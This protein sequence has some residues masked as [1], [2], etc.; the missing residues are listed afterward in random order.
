MALLIFV[1][2]VS[3]ILVFGA[4]YASEWSRLPDDDVS[5]RIETA[6]KSLKDPRSA[7]DEVIEPTQP[8]PQQAHLPS[9]TPRHLR[10]RLPRAGPFAVK[11][12]HQP[13]RRRPVETSW[14]ELS[15]S[16]RRTLPTW[17]STV[18]SLIPSRC[19]IRLYA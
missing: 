14:R 17:V 15:W 18:R 5:V 1:Y 2:A 12:V 10:P 11:V 16:L 3:L 7:A 8:S 6:K 19:A 9:I 13:A 4:E